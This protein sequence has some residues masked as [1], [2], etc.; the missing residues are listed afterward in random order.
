MKK[1]KLL[2]IVLL[3]GI[4]ILAT[5]SFSACGGIDYARVVAKIQEDYYEKF[6]SMEFIF[7]DFQMENIKQFQYYCY[8]N[9]DNDGVPLSI[10]SR[11]IV[12]SL[13]KTGKKHAQQAID[14][15]NT[16]GFI[17]SA[18]WYYRGV[19]PLILYDKNHI[20]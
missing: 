2:G 20:W 9:Y 3:L 16:L 17:D 7:E 14:H 5:T 13:K 4:L 18:C 1:V 15:L 12:L 19:V 8:Y 6:D 10:D 11:F